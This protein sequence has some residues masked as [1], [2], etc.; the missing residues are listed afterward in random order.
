MGVPKKIILNFE[1]KFGNL[2]A[3]F[4]FINF[5]EI[6]QQIWIDKIILKRKL[7]KKFFQFPALCGSKMGKIKI[8][9]SS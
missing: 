2:S 5:F 9:L 7:L 8:F 1:K 4:S 6:S 3:I